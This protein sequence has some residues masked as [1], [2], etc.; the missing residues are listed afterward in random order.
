MPVMLLY[1]TAFI[2]GDGEVHFVK[3]AYGWDHELLQRI[4]EQ[5]YSNA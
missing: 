5:K 1:W 3:D 2:G 4:A